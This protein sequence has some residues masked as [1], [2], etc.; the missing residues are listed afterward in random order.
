MSTTRNNTDSVQMKGLHWILYS[1]ETHTALYRTL[2]IR[3]THMEC[4]IT[5]NVDAAIHCIHQRT[6]P[7]SVPRTETRHLSCSLENCE[8]LWHGQAQQNKLFEF[9]ECERSCLSW[10]NTTCV[11]S[12]V[13]LLLWHL[14]CSIEKGGK[15]QRGQMEHTNCLTRNR[16]QAAL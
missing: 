16:G 10:Q 13:T 4:S 1:R 7:A 5:C 9:T 14:S 2:Y 11:C 6:K 12:L 8:N 15:L 3:K